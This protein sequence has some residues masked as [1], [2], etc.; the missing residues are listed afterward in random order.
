MPGRGQ[1]ESDDYAWNEERMEGS[2]RERTT[3]MG[4]SSCIVRRED[5]SGQGR[6]D[7]NKVVERKGTRGQVK[8]RMMNGI[9]AAGGSE[10]E[11]QFH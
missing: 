2:V 10:E 4:L 6:S 5:D 1:V 7:L 8:P 9:W 3:K 11:L